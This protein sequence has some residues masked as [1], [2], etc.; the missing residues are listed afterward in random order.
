MMR[1]SIAWCWALAVVL[2]ST[3]R[4]DGPVQVPRLR[5]SWVREEAARSC[6]DVRG[7]ERAVRERLG[8]DPFADTAELAA[9]VLL[10]HDETGFVA[11][12]QLR[13]S[14][15]ELQGER[16]LRSDQSCTTL[17]DAV[18][19]ALALYI[20]PDA[21]LAPRASPQPPAAPAAS[22]AERLTSPRQAPAPAPAAPAGPR[23]PRGSL[24]GAAALAHG[25]LPGIAVGARLEGEL[26]LGAGFRLLASGVFF[27]EQS[28]GG[29][30]FAFGLGAGGLGGCYEVHVGRV[31]LAPCAALV[32]GE[33]H[34]VVRNLEPT[35]PGGH[36]WLAASLLARLRVGLV[37]S[38]FAELGAGAWLPF[39]PERFRV[40]GR[41][42]TVFSQSAA[43]PALALGIGT[44]F[45]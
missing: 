40:M 2:A 5:V 41:S 3:A 20:D 22:H 6:P 33:L 36:L 34:S 42:Q 7:V 37:S 15:G 28:T 8:R 30:D 25:L 27:P 11:R 35:R 23:G 24:S 12:I 16:I 19:L 44:T 39:T 26:A 17:A 31:A 45:R 10:D 38:V 14:Q 13:T 18:A 4:A 43:A 9:E 1:L 29:G 21:A 32:A